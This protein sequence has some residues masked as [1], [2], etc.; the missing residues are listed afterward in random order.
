[1]IPSDIFFI[2]FAQ[3]VG[4]VFS[5]LLGILQAFLQAPV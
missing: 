3:F 1:M 4:F 2:I 5:A